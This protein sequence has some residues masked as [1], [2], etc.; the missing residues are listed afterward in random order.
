[1]FAALAHLMATMPRIPDNHYL[2]LLLY[3]RYKGNQKMGTTMQS[4]FFMKAFARSALLLTVVMALIF[5][6]NDAKV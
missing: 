3:L 2:F 6:K 5:L 1:M 4:T